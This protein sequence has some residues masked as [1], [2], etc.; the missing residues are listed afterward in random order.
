MKLLFII[1]IFVFSFLDSKDLLK[2]SSIPDESINELHKKFLPLTQYLEKEINMKIKFVPVTDYAAV[3]EALATKKIDLAWLGGFTFVQAQIR[4]N[5]NIKPIIQRQKDE[6]FKSVFISHK[7]SKIKSLKDL[8][9]TS[10]A[11]GSP[12]STSG[13]LMPRYFLLEKNINPEKYFKK[14]AYSGA[15]DATVFAVLGRKVDAGVLN[16]VVW[17]KLKKKNKNIFDNVE[18]FFTTENY[19]DYNWSLINDVEKNVKDKIIKA[20]LK[21]N[22]KENAEILELQGAEKYITTK[23]ENYRQIEKAAIKAKLLN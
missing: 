22:K 18:V 3:V 4:S 10:F 15:H 1:F 2:V 20:F 14:I 19:Y 17:E 16:S 8:K 12:S 5:G 21:L 7:N 6:K 23:K 9:N 11:F 13:H